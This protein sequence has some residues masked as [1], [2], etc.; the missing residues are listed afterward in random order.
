MEVPFLTII[1]VNYNDATGLKKTITSVV[2]QSFTN[3][4]YII[5]DGGSNDGSVTVIEEFSDTLTYWVSEKDNGVFNAMNKGIK[6]ANGTYIQFLNSGDVF[7]SPTA[8]EDFIEHPNFEGDIIYGDYK[9]EDGE[10]IYPDSLYPAYFIKTSLP[11]QSTLFKKTVF[12]TMGLY[13]EDYVIA[14]DRAFYIKCYLSNHF[15]FKHIPCFL[16]LFD[17]EGISN[18]PAFREKKE[19]E[20]E[21]IF[22]QLFG[23]KYQEHKNQ[24]ALEKRL[25]R[26]KRNSLSGILKRVL[27]KIKLL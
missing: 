5:I 10:K 26:K 24:I 15:I 25:N 23:E 12:D 11:H 14:S 20:D 4:E 18:N 1:T 22:K 6:K 16:V 17:K 7:T 19:I 13:N 3:F 2:S 8:L 9:F 21:T 27:N